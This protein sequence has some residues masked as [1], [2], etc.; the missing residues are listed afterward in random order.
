MF[1]WRVKDWVSPSQEPTGKIASM[2]TRETAIQRAARRTQTVLRRVGEAL[3]IARVGSGTSTRRLGT[4][5][6]ISHTQV[7]R[8]ER[9]AAPHVDIEVIARMASAL[10]C[11]LSMSVH[12]IAAPVRDAGHLALLAEFRSRLHPSLRWRT[13]VPIPI[14][15]DQRSADGVIDGRGFDGIV[16]AETHVDDIQAAVRRLRGK[17]RDLGTTRAIIVIADTRHNRAVL[18]HVPEL[19]DQFPVPTRAC[20]ASLARGLDPGGDCLVLLR[21]GMPSKRREVLRGRGQVQ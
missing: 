18:D 19:R 12:P 1:R 17:Q 3:R 5:V 11:E 8:I 6:G 10:G 7:L 9:G 14:A 2:P 20:L 13:E 15:G 16:E 4:L 21:P